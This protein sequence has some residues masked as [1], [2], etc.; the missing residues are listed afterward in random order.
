MSTNP[1]RAIALILFALAVAVGVG[2]YRLDIGTFVNPGPG[3]TPLLYACALGGL[4]ILLFI[5][6]QSSADQQDIVVQ[7]RSVASILA[8]LFAYALLIEWLGYIVSTLF[9][10]FMLFQ[11]AGV[12][13]TRSI[14]F[15]GLATTV[16]HVVFV[17][18]LL[19]PLP[20]GSIFP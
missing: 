15:A 17:R 8:I 16:V 11:V 7:W 4:S 1:D 20:I 12:N 3:L 14:L 2:A 6:V 19:V 5:R 13:R 10:M 18:W 9:V